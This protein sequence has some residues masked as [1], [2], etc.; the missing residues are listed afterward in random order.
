MFKLLFR[1]ESKIEKIRQA[2]KQRPFFNAF[3]AF[4][5]LDK[6]DLG[7]LT[8]HEF[9]DLLISYGFESTSNELL[10]LIKRFDKDRDGKVSYCEF[11]EEFTPKILTKM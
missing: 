3:D 11:V 10:N 1:N 6:N 8:L 7:F 9:Q 5:A 4:R 2:V